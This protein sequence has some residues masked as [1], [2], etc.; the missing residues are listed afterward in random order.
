MSYLAT[1][2][3]VRHMYV[4]NGEIAADINGGNKGAIAVKDFTDGGRKQVYLQYRSGNDG[5]VLRSDIIDVQNIT[6]FTL[7]KASRDLR[8]LRQ[9]ALSF[10]DDT[11]DPI[12]GETY[13][14]NLTF[15]QFLSRSDIDEYNRNASV[16]AYQGM[17]QSD[18]LLLLAFTIKASLY[19]DAWNLVDVYLSTT[20]NAA[21]VALKDADLSLLVGTVGVND[22]VVQL[23]T[24]Y[25]G[26]YKAIIFKEKIQ[27]FEQGVHEDKPVFFDV[28]PGVVMRNSFEYS[29]GLVKPIEVADEANYVIYN[30]TNEYDD[31]LPNATHLPNGR[32]VASLEWATTA[33]RG[34]TD[35][36][37]NWPMNIK[38]NYEV[39]PNAQYD[40]IDIHFYKTLSQDSVQKSEKQLTIAVPANN[41]AIVT[42][43]ETATGL[44]ADV[45][46]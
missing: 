7:V 9:V 35:K 21:D 27:P 16:I 33:M 44:T 11:H 26:N 25:K 40:M 22:A 5:D 24:K 18:V 13:G 45:R 36:D 10:S 46:Q 8:P 43:L 37:F 32:K 30:G 3:Q 20:G 23:K 38:T 31:G 34:D 12:Q 6:Q 28:R 1:N 15:R 19:K 29:W 17:E 4:A 42:A 2:N 41:T 39:N 14:F